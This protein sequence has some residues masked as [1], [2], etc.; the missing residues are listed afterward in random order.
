MAKNKKGPAPKYTWA[1]CTPPKDW[2]TSTPHPTF[3]DADGFAIP[4]THNTQDATGILDGFQT[5]ATDLSPFTC[6]KGAYAGYNYGGQMTTTPKKAPAK[7][8]QALDAAFAKAKK[9]Y[10]EDPIF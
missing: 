4:G 7:F 3:F 9:T 8:N 5:C 10:K 2:K 1:L 6:L